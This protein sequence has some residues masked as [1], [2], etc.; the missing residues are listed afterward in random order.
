MRNASFGP[1]AGEPCLEQVNAE[2]GRGLSVIV[3]TIGSGKST[4]LQGLV[5]HLPVGGRGTGGSGGGGS[6]GGGSGGGGSGGD[7]VARKV[8][9]VKVEVLDRRV[10]FCPDNPWIVNASAR[11]NVCLGSPVESFDEGLYRRC[12]AA[13]ALEEDFGEWP[14]GDETVIGAKGITVSGGQK[15]R[16]SL[17]RA[18]YS[19]CGV[20]L[21][22]DPLSALDNI[23]G[24]WVFKRAVCEMARDAAVVMT[25][26]QQQYMR[27]EGCKVFVIG[28]GRLRAEGEG[29]LGRGVVGELA[30]GASRDAMGEKAANGGIGEPHAGEDEEAQKMSKLSAKVNTDREKGGVSMGVYGGYLQACGMVVVAIALAASVLAQVVNVS[31]EV[32]LAVWSDS[33]EGRYAAVCLAVMAMNLFR[34]FVV[35]WLGL[36]ASETLHRSLL[37]KDEPSGR[38]DAAVG[39]GGGGSSGCGINATI[40][41]CNQNF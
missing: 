35:C 13:C 12:I 34:F 3:G 41:G 21:L 14:E 24:N 22:D 33:P 19:E 16:I 30:P 39:F 36:R 37:R 25:T 26:H 5:E 32:V 40:D 20:V 9:E 38:A 8:G 29:A 6:G 27:E 4:L 1:V 15:A 23:V 10:A 28:D 17:A 31:K 2:M 7:I 18:M 11:D